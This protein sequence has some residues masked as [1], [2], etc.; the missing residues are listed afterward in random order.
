MSAG[1]SMVL[2]RS[3]SIAIEGRSRES[4]LEVHASYN[5]GPH[6]IVAVFLIYIPRSRCPSS[7][8]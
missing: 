6:G 3:V 1:S 7:S 8:Q 5:L 2:M 4:G